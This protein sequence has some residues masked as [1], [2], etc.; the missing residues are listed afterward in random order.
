MDVN[1]AFTNGVHCPVLL[2][3]GRISSKVPIMMIAAN[4]YT[5]TMREGS[6]DFGLVIAWTGTRQGSMRGILNTLSPGFGLY[7]VEL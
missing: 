5:S 1:R 2:D 3:T 7:L 6:L 4:P